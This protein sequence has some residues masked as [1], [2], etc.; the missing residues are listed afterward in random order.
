MP[1]STDRKFIVNVELGLSYTVTKAPHLHSDGVN[2]VDPSEADGRAFLW[3]EGNHG[4]RESAGL[5][6]M[7]RQMDRELEAAGIE[8]IDVL[9]DNGSRTKATVFP[10]MKTGVAFV[11][12]VLPTL[13]EAVQQAQASES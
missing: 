9:L 8:K 6:A 10:D 3:Y 13:Q 7:R 4:L 1:K 12:S 5:H 2:S 11:E